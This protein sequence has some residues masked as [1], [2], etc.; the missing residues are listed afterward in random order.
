M[1]CQFCDI[2][3]QKKWAFVISRENTHLVILDINPATAGHSL[4]IPKDHYENLNDLPLEIFSEI[5]ASAK[6]MAEILR[7]AM[8]SSGINII[9][10]DGKVAGQRVNHFHLHIIPRYPQDGH[11][12]ILKRGIKREGMFKESMEKI[13][14]VMNEMNN[15]K[16]I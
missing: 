5:T 1:R 3:N 14:K 11:S 10:N 13:K 8:G 2:A 9:I 7:K 4:I 16:G 15:L 12:F 6:R